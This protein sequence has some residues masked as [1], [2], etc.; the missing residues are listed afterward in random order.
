MGQ[1]RRKVRKTGGPLRLIPTEGTPDGVVR[2][3]GV[4]AHVNR[5]VVSIDSCLISSIMLSATYRGSGLLG[6]VSRVAAAFRG[7]TTQEY[8]PTV[9]VGQPSSRS[10]IGA[11]RNGGGKKSGVSPSVV[12]VDVRRSNRFTPGEPPRPCTA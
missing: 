7:M 2:P 8:D 3:L 6:R 5:S 12:V 11:I 1:V 10:T 9:I 4:A